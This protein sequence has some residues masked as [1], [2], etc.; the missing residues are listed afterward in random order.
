MSPYENK[1]SYLESLPM[2]K[3]T[4]ELNQERFSATGDKNGLNQ[5]DEDYQQDEVMA[6]EEKGKSSTRLTE[7]I[8][9]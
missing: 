4:L 7:R 6:L 5:E 3:V 1:K 9:T 8:V 2:L